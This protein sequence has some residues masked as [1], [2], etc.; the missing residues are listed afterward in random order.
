MRE[1]SEMDT[2]Q[3]DV[4]NACHLRCANCT[5]HIGHHKTP[6]FMEPELVEKAIDSLEGFEGRIGLMGGEPFMHP[7][8]KEII[9][10]FSKK[11]HRRKRQIWTAGFNWEK[12]KDWEEKVKRDKVLKDLQSP[13]NS[14]SHTLQIK[15]DISLWLLRR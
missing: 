7:Q 5:R 10:I 9:E 14:S 8:I 12:N 3:I 6:F 11:T 2:I 15:D 13:L 4:T 1:L